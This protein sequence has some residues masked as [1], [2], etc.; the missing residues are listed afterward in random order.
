MF[1][2]GF[3]KMLMK[4]SFF[5]IFQNPPLLTK[6]SGH[7]VKYAIF[8][9]VKKHSIWWESKISFETTNFKIDRFTE[10][11][12]N[13]VFSERFSERIF[14]TQLQAQT[15]VL[16]CTSV[17]FWFHWSQAITASQNYLG[18]EWILQ[19]TLPRQSLK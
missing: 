15:Q 19:E 5:L 3:K 12:G 18:V 8:I 13:N 16:V 10:L 14:S 11:L 17:M 9:L 4:Y 6:S 7:C 2:V 1:I